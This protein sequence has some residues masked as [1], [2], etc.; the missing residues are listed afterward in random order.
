MRTR[1]VDQADETG[2]QTTIIQEDPEPV[3]SEYASQ[4]SGEDR[5]THAGPADVA[6]GAIRTVNL[7]ILAL[8]A[9]VE[10]LL[11][12]RLGFLVAG[13]NPANDFVDFIYDATGWLVDPFEGIIANESVDGGGVF[14][15]A[16]VIAMVVYAVAALL[17]ILLLSA[18]AS[19]P[20]PVAEHSTVSRSSRQ[21]RTA[22]E[23]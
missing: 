6:R 12:F 2:R 8:L 16:T 7:V 9:L 19:F 4:V 17:I 5:I 14:E 20:S 11:A 23:H 22:H 15:W 1:R 13:A 3:E 21:E 18:I 10:T